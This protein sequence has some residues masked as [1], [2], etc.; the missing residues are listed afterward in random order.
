[1]TK[2]KNVEGE[3]GIYAI[4]QFYSFSLRFKSNVKEMMSLLTKKRPL[5]D[6]SIIVLMIL[7]YFFYFF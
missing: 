2:N 3:N 4:R 7:F 5:E 6:W 1:M